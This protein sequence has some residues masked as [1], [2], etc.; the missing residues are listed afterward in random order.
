MAQCTKIRKKVQFRES[1]LRRGIN[2]K[3]LWSEESISK[4]V[5]FMVIVHCIA[6]YCIIFLF[7]A[8][9]TVHE[10]SYEY[11]QMDLYYFDM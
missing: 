3:V 9:L 8:Q 2:Q 5:A 6:L 4:N 7:L 1:A 10:W 11:N